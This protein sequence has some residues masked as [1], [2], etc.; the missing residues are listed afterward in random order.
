MNKLVRLIKLNNLQYNANRDPQVY[1][2]TA[3]KPFRIQ[4]MLGGS[5]KARAKVDVDGRTPCNESVDLPGTFTCNVVFD[6]P[7]VRIATLFV[8]GVGESFSHDIR[9]DVMEHD[10]IG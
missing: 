2:S 7:G 6:T 3:H 4:A 9:L 8:E 5:G 10:W 1:R